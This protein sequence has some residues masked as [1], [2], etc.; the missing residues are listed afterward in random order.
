M[1]PLLYAANDIEGTGD[2]GDI[3]DLVDP[4][5][6]VDT[7]EV[8]ACQPSLHADEAGLTP[9][10]SARFRMQEYIGQRYLQ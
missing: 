10:R 7:A 5:D 4:V 3:V 9:R 8:V 6:P 2:F 1:A